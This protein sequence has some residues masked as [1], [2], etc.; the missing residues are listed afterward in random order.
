[1][2]S[3]KHHAWNKS[4]CSSIDLTNTYCLFYKLETGLGTESAVINQICSLTWQCLFIKDGNCSFEEWWSFWGR[5]SSR[6]KVEN[7][8]VFA[9]WRLR[10]HLKRLEPEL[11]SW[12][13]DLHS[14]MMPSGQKG[15]M[16]GFM[17]CDHSL[18]IFTNLVFKLVFGRW[19][20]E[21][22]WGIRVSKGDRV[23]IYFAIPWCPIHIEPL[24][25]PTNTEFWWT[26]N[27]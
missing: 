14:H 12:V 23:N 4:K 18:K 21:G 8:I 10:S 27:V 3:C 2:W 15:P 19:S 25:C 7:L 26:H 6:R 20:L 9:R 5:E 16:L 13:C 22:Q 24:W 1:M 17:L 11:I